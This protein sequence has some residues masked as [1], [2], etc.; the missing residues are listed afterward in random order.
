MGKEKKVTLS[1]PLHPSIESVPFLPPYS[2]SELTSLYRMALNILRTGFTELCL[3]DQEVFKTE[4]QYEVL[5]RLLGSQS[6]SSYCL[7]VPRNRG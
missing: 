5:L 7:E 2:M 4:E 1:R 6:T 3:K